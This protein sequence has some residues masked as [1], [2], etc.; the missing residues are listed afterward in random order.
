MLFISLMILLILTLLGVSS[1]N[2][3]LMEEKMASNSQIST[4]TFQS[5][6]SAIR[7]TYYTAN[8]NDASRSLALTRAESNT[9]IAL[10]TAD[11]TDRRATLALPVIKQDKRCIGDLNSSE[12]LFTGRAIEIVGNASMRGIQESNVQGYTICNMRP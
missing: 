4:T 1:L 12:G 3:S 8:T 6:E 10:A 9:T 7:T 11:G 5:A 2:G